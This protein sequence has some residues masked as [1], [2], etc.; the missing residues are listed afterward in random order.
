MKLKLLLSVFVL[1]FS[2]SLVQSAPP[3]NYNN[4]LKNVS[5]NTLSGIFYTDS[6][7]S[8]FRIW[9]DINQGIHI[10]SISGRHYTNK[11]FK[12]KANA[13]LSKTKSINSKIPVIHTSDSGIRT[14]FY[15][16]I[17][18]DFQGFSYFS[19]NFSE[20]CIN[21]AYGTFNQTYIELS[22]G[23][24]INLSTPIN[25]SSATATFSNI[26]YE[27]ST[28]LLINNTGNA[29]ILSYFQVPFNITYNSTVMDANFTSFDVRNTSTGVSIPFWLDSNN[30]VNGSY[31]NIW[32]NVTSIASGWD[33]TSYAL[34]SK[35]ITGI[36]KSNG[37]NTFTKF[38]DGTT[39]SGW[40]GTGATLQGTYIDI[41][42]G[43]GQYI[44]T[45]E[46]IDRPAIIEASLQYP[47]E[48]DSHVSM[49]GLFGSSGTIIYAQ[50]GYN[51]YR[52]GD[53]N[54]YIRFYETAEDLG[55]PIFS[56]T[57]VRHTLKMIWGSTIDTTDT[58]KDGVQRADP[59]S[60]FPA[61]T[62]MYL[63][64]GGRDGVDNDQIKLYYI[65]VRK[66]ASPE[67]IGSVGVSVPVASNFYV[68]PSGHPTSE[69]KTS[70]ESSVLINISLT[71]GNPLS[72][73][74]FLKNTSG[75]FDITLNLIVF[76]DVQIVYESI[77]ST[78]LYCQNISYTP[79]VNL[80]NISIKSLISDSTFKNSLTQDFINISTSGSI[81][82]SSANQWNT[83]INILNVTQSLTYWY[84]S[85]IPFTLPIVNDTSLLVLD[86]N[87]IF[88]S[89]S[90]N[91]YRLNNKTM[92]YKIYL[93]NNVSTN[94]YNFSS[95]LV[96]GSKNKLYIS[97]KR[98]GTILYKK[99]LTEN[100]KDI[101]IQ[102]NILVKTNKFLYVFDKTNYS[103]LYKHSIT[104]INEVGYE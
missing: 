27:Y 50:Q 48:T 92:V 52:A 24:W 39:L 96:Y 61:A 16:D 60:Q 35:N 79:I 6:F 74:Q 64:I 5:D 55:S 87:D 91:I 76:D 34:F 95:N 17:I 51:L 63:K 81:I 62:Q 100:I 40:A 33:N 11:V 70:S 75:T 73:M 99:F 77:C 90:N 28:P 21:C 42:H 93:N 82:N 12:V 32:V 26:I 88:L 67:P 25:V 13:F 19:L 89:K 57:T 8:D 7:A 54:Y 94:L 85:T 36:S 41:P 56:A 101:S 43:V 29:T 23:S 59:T 104:N 46:V 14:I 103:L 71:A 38:A 102:E 49:F 97:D 83:T 80:T 10:K 3:I 30:T 53:F 69:N 1:L 15:I 20:N 58:Y 47:V 22:N 2:I 78:L 68:K 86:N 31:A 44:S 72:N 98:N 9:Y 65:F 18:P 45:V 37:T 4:E 66:Y 84:N